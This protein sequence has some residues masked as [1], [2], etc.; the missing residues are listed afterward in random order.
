MFSVGGV[1]WVVFNWIK[2]RRGWVVVVDDNGAV[3]WL[4]VVAR[5]W[6]FPLE[7]GKKA[8]KGRK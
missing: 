3:E 2:E 7:K 1:G 5:W 6:L 8:K 4:A